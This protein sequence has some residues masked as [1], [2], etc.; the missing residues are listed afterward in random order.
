MK[1]RLLA[2]AL[3]AAGSILALAWTSK[4]IQADK[5]RIDCVTTAVAETALMVVCDT[6]S[7][8]CTKEE[9]RTKTE[10][11]Y[12]TLDIPVDSWPEVW[13]EPIAGRLLEARYVEGKLTPISACSNVDMLTRQLR[14]SE[15]TLYSR[16]PVNH[17]GPPNLCLRG[18]S[19]FIQNLL[20]G[21]TP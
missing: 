3:L 1:K 15:R 10:C 16:P 4:P 11:E 13:G 14:A 7:S 9:G 8:R 20:D 6:P 2:F 19:G 17:A 5:G 21:G 18:V 12:T